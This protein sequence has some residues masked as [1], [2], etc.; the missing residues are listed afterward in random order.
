[1][2]TE[3]ALQWKLLGKKA[4]RILRIVDR[5]KAGLM[6]SDDLEKDGQP[7]RKAPEA[8][9]LLGKMK[10]KT[11]YTLSSD[12]AEEIEGLAGDIVA[13]SENENWKHRAPYDLMSL[14]A[15]I[16][17][18]VRMR[19]FAEDGDLAALANY[20]ESEKSKGTKAAIWLTQMDRFGSSSHLHT[21]LKIARN[22]DGFEAGAAGNDL[23]ARQKFPAS[24]RPLDKID[25]QA[26]AL[27]NC[28]GLIRW[29]I[30]LAALELKNS[31]SYN[32]GSGTSRK[33]LDILHEG[34]LAKIVRIAESLDASLLNSG[35][36]GKAFGWNGTGEKLAVE[37]L[38][39]VSGGKLSV[40][41]WYLGQMLSLIED[42]KFGELADF[43]EKTLPSKVKMR[44]DGIGAGVVASALLQDVQLKLA[45]G[46][47]KKVQ[48]AA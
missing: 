32:I 44:K 42:G 6:S 7:L 23:I 38:H 19:E 9:E 2:G 35:N 40:R 27:R 25:W 48:Q 30:G 41:I 28:I 15:R 20:V 45:L 37:E 46:E 14:A 5:E 10:G 8:N 21:A 29:K 12:D 22:P 33:T 26:Q 24:I 16:R 11:R 43:W 39:A 36:A 34:E 13:Q 18:L 17:C 3:L 1:M 31:A 4:A 47:M